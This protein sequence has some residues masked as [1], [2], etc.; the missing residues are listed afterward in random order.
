MK[1]LRVREA[2]YI[3]KVLAAMFSGWQRILPVLS[4]TCCMS[5]VCQQLLWAGIQQIRSLALCPE[6]APVQMRAMEPG[7]RIGKMRSLESMW[8]RRRWTYQ[9]VRPPGGDCHGPVFKEP[10]EVGVH[11]HPSQGYIAKRK[12]GASPSRMAHSQ[13]PTQHI[14]KA[15]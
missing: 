1:E 5:P 8:G 10:W 15:H 12:S 4:V 11:P 7:K 14:R 2:K 13:A 9:A 6:R 3:R